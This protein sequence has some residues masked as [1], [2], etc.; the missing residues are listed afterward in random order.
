[1]GLQHGLGVR[2]CDDSAYGTAARTVSPDITDSDDSVTDGVCL[3]PCVSDR[4]VPFYLRV[5]LALVRTAPATM[6]LKTFLVVSAIVV[7]SAAG[8]KAL[9]PTTQHGYPRRTVL[10]AAAV[11]PGGQP[12]LVRA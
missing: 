6:L 3:S 2:A 1:M 11:T 9:L 7:T 10:T 8:S 12:R 5:V 4:E